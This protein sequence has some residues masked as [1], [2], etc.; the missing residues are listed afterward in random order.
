MFT[1]KKSN[2]N[3]LRQNTVT[4]QVKATSLG[5]NGKSKVKNPDQD[6]NVST[7]YAMPTSMG[8]SSHLSSNAVSIDMEP[9]LTGLTPQVESAFYRL[10]R[11]IYY[12]DS[13][14]GSAVDLISQ[15]TYSSEFSLGGINNDAISQK[16]EEVIER[17]NTRTLLPEMSTDYLVLGV[18]CSSL[19][20]NKQ[21]K[22]FADM[23]CHPVESL[24]ITD[25][26]FYSQD[27]I[28][29]VKF[30]DKV[31]SA[32]SG[33]SPTVNNLRE[34]V[35]DS[36][37]EK[38]RSGSLDL[39]PLTTIYIPRKTF[40]YT[41]MG[42]SYFKRILPL[43][44][45]EKNL[46]RGTLVESARRQ[47]GILHLTLGD[48]DEWIPQVADMEFITDLFMCLS[49]GNLLHTEDGLKRI[50]SICSREGMEKDT[51]KEVDFFLK[52]ADGEMC[53]ATKWWY[54]GYAPTLKVTTD[55]GYS[56]KA[57]EDHR[58]Y[59]LTEKGLVWKK[60]KDLN[61]TDYLCVDTSALS[62]KRKPLN[63]GEVS[64]HSNDNNSK[65]SYL[66]K[67]MT[68]N[69]AYVIGLTLA[70]GNF[71][72]D[73]LRISNSDKNVLNKYCSCLE[74]FGF[75]A[76]YVKS[77]RQ[78]KGSKYNINGVIGTRKQH[79]YGIRGTS[80]RLF[81]RYLENIGVVKKHTF[82]KSI[83][84]SILE[85]TVE[86]QAAFLAGMIDGDG[87]LE[88]E[89]YRLYSCSPLMLKQVQ[90]MLSNMGILSNIAQDYPFLTT[91]PYHSQLLADK[92]DKHLARESLRLPVE[93]HNCKKSGVP[94]TW[95]TAII[96]DRLVEK[97]HGKGTVFLNDKN[98]PVLIP[99][100][101]IHSNQPTLSS[102][103]I[104]AICNDTFNCI[105]YTS[106]YNSGKYDDF[107]EMV[108]I[109]SE[110]AYNSL[111]ELLNA[112]YTLLKVK[113]IKSCGKK[114]LYDLTISNETKP[115]F[116]SNGIL[117]H[118]SADSDPLG[119]VVATRTGVQVEEVRSGGDFW[120][121]T[122]F[123]DSILPYKLRALGISEAF[124]SGDA[125]YNVA[126]A[127]MTIF[128]EMLRA[129]RDM[130]TRKFFYD[131]LFP[132]IS[133]VNGYTVNAKGR[134]SIRE[135]LKK[136]ESIADGLRRMNDGS[137]LLIPSVIWAKQLKPEG[138]STYLDMLNSMTEKGVP[139]PLRVLA[140]AGGLNLDELLRQKDD[141]LD[142]RKQIQ[143][144]TKAI[145]KINPPP[146][147]EGTGEA[148]MSAVQLRSNSGNSAV[149]QATKGKR[150]S[151][152]SREFN[153]E[154]YNV[155]KTGKPLPMS[156]SAQKAKNEKIDRTIAKVMR[157]NNVTVRPR[158]TSF[159]TSEDS[160]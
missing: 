34:L 148:A 154:L 151:L 15:V 155:S 90:I 87:S 121:V 37:L 11:D 129:Y 4:K 20:Y 46:F 39:D 52:G 79:H 124:L 27:P 100:T 30:G 69:L 147:E 108:K 137:K 60:L 106:E 59:A 109:I 62:P 144:Y 54:R 98:T 145:S 71:N 31:K 16:Y 56:V 73:G 96:K 84:Q 116:I 132:L 88:A 75:D 81:I 78:V 43:Y 5:S 135:D 157:T 120:K 160:F 95:L 8:P 85:S 13:V 25:I 105:L 94:L 114:H 42:T 28:I 134:I 21:K 29:N 86:C 138:D 159:N 70:E 49:G 149:L 41:E 12:F 153:S 9:L 156:A 103:W 18:H 14:A 152:L 2:N 61:F 38:I 26:P 57:T 24:T 118:N 140:A 33:N 3:A 113:S 125:N 127:S 150:P 63:W 68:T 107:L 141:D 48:G 128:V 66:P 130:L 80:S 158:R 122:D 6:D 76:Y 97:V 19:L 112:K 139:V 36:I 133:M 93:S 65:S 1:I 89:Q 72:K 115:A 136:A 64:L 82:K 143:E 40:S 131:R 99:H 104:K 47:R 91:S 35:G 17:L 32:V 50:D 55:Y 77:S 58:V 23:I 102:R 44:L 92:I 142:A 7:S 53:R 45:I 10:Y 83:P 146:A 74:S 119:A 22:V 101:Y 126:D 111:M 123:S 67:Y 117:V 110:S 51:Y